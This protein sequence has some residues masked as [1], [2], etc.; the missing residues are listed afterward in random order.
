MDETELWAKIKAAFAAGT[1]VN[2][3]AKDF[4]V[5]IAEILKRAKV[6]GWRRAAEHR[7]GLPALPPRTAD[8]APPDPVAEAAADIIR[9]HRERTRTHRD[10]YD[11]LAQEFQAMTGM[12]VS[13]LDRD[14][15]DKVRQAATPGDAI[16]LLSDLLK[17][18]AVKFSMFER[19]TGMLDAIIK[20]ERTVWGLNDTDDA[21]ESTQ[22]DDLLEMVRG[23]SLMR[24]LPDN[25]IDFDRRM[26]QGGKQ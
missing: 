25:V 10:Q 4:D 16:K 2:Q 24:P 1:K 8:Q 5:S 19:L 12:L 22:W 21:P 20:I 7:V 23:P 11:L 15:M 18:T 13:F 14:Q 9:A 26:Q 6:E 17:A 3:L